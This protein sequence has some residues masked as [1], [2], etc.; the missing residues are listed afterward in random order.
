V[1]MAGEPPLKKAVQACRHAMKLF[2][3]Q[4]NSE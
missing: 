2:V 4:H 1:G 3:L